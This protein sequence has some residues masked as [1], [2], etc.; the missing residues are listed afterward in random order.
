MVVKQGMHVVT[1]AELAAW[2]GVV[3][4]SGTTSLISLAGS[5]VLSG[6]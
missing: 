5:T 2:H 4:E 6:I 3:S 1:V